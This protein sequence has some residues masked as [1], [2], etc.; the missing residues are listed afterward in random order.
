MT[1][2]FVKR[3]RSIPIIKIR[4]YKYKENEDANQSYS[5]Q[6][7]ESSWIISIFYKEKE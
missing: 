5:L 1:T 4:F 7:E 6:S 2:I 3:K